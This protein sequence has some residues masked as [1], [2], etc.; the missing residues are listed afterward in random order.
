MGLEP[1]VRRGLKASELDLVYDGTV[2]TD[3][4]MLLECA[5][6]DHFVCLPDVEPRT[7][8]SGLFFRL[9]EVL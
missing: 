8:L 2:L 7:T 3:G 4:K 5:P 6:P 9:Y 1:R